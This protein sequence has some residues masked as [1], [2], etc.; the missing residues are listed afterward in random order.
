MAFVSF[1]MDLAIEKL[2]NLHFSWI[3]STRSTTRGLTGIL[4]T[5]TIWVSFSVILTTGCSIFVHYVS[6][7]AIGS[8]IPGLLY[9]LLCTVLQTGNQKL[10]IRV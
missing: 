10:T 8:G 5:Y 2:G 9:S 1:G 3:K 6:P 4:A 7:Q